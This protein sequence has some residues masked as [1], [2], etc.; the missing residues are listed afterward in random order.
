MEEIKNLKAN[1]ASQTNIEKV[2]A[3][4]TSG[5]ETAVKENDYWLYNLEQKY[6][7]NEDPTSILKMTKW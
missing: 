5:M 1:G 3:E 6:Y 2:I 7:R 4:D